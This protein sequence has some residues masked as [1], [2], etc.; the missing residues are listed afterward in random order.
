MT[1]GD[2]LGDVKSAVAIRFWLNTVDSVYDTR[3]DHRDAERRG[4][5]SAVA[6]GNGRLGNRPEV[7]PAAVGLR[8]RQRGAGR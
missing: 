2:P 5:V 3:R 1:R 7:Q 4:D 8:N 6:D